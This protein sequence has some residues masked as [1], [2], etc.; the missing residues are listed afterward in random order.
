MRQKPKY[1]KETPEDKQFRM[2]LVTMIGSIF[3]CMACLIGTTWAFFQTTITSADNV[4][5]IGKLEVAV[6]LIRGDQADRESIDPSG[7]YTY[8][9]DEVGTYSI[10][11]IN[12]GSIPGFCTIKLTDDLGN[13]ESFSTGTLNPAGED[14]ED[15]ATI[16]LTVTPED[17]LNEILPVTLEI[18]PHW[19]EDPAY[20]I[21]TEDAEVFVPTEETTEETE[22][23]TPED[24][25]ASNL[26]KNDEATDSTT[27]AEETTEATKPEA[28]TEATA[29][30]TTTEATEEVTEP[31]TTTEATQT[32]ET[33]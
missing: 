10:S 7:Q 13:V 14:L 24:S 2:V 9:L 28:T 12:S 27:A 30:V 31:V 15:T 23:E 17:I 22:G 29:P 32:T 1:L 5:E 33:E 11:L 3:L 25:T 20:T 6:A 16:E 26:P 18:T 4:I 8:K 19:G 21:A